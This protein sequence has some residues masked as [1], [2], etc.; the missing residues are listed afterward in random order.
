MNNLADYGLYTEW[1]GHQLGYL[2]GEVRTLR[3]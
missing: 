3:K 2:H 1:L